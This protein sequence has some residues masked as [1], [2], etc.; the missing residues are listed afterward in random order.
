MIPFFE[1][2]MVIEIFAICA[3]GVA[4]FKKCV[5]ICMESESWI[6]QI[7]RKGGATHGLQNQ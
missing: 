4:F 1:K 2:R 5:T 6:Y 3:F 7:T